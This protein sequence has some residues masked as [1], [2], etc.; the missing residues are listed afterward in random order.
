[1]RVTRLRAFVK[2]HYWLLLLAVLTA[3]A[4]RILV[5]SGYMIQTAPTRVAV[6]ICT[7]HGT[8]MVYLDRGKGIDDQERKDRDAA[9]RC[10]FADL[11]VP[12]LPGVPP[13]ELALALA[14]ILALWLAVAD[15]LRLAQSTRLRPPLRG[16]PSLS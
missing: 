10:A 15:P 11:A 3:L 16:P 7:A 6:S 13:L 14:F 9:N 4:L 5:P 2:R 1:M 12:G 8:E